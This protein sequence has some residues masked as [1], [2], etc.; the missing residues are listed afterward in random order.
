MN[1]RLS[2]LGLAAAAALAASP[3]ITVDVTSPWSR[4]PTS[5]EA[6]P[7]ATV[8]QVVGTD[9][10][11][12]I[13]YHRPSA[14]GRDVWTATSSRGS[15]I[16][17]SDG[18]VWRAGANER[19]TFESTGD[20][21]IEGKRLPAGRYGLFMIPGDDAWTLVLNEAADGWGTGGY[22]A[23]ADV[24]RVELTPTSGPQTESMMFGFDDVGDGTSR[25]FL[26]WTDVEVPF[27]IGAASSD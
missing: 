17:P 9:T 19:T 3:F 6:S 14:R 23:E 22:D 4:A 27:T 21:L 8:A 25:G 13:A 7:G 5:A 26:R 1:A 18:S 11:V 12:Q 15:A 2:L 16:V 10:W 24:L 20:V